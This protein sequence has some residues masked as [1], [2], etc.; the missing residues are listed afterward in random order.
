MK[1]FEHLSHAY[2]LR[3]FPHVGIGRIHF[4]KGNYNLASNHFEM[5]IDLGNND[6]MLHL[7]YGLCEYKIGRYKKAYNIFTGIDKSGYYG[8]D[9]VSKVATSYL[10]N[11]KLSVFDK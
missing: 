5:A 6:R 1:L 10:S 8:E 4:K 11:D 3:A 7:W 2:P 9:G